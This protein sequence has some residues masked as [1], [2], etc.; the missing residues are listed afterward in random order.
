MRVISGKYRGVTISSPFG[1]RTHPMSERMRSALFTTLG[2]IQGLSVL[3]AYAGSGALGIEA[4]SRGAANVQFIEKDKNAFKIIQKNISK[5]GSNNYKLSR[6]NCFSWS[7]NNEQLKY[8]LI[9]IDPPYN[10]VSTEHI[11]QLTSNLKQTGLLVLS[12][13]RNMSRPPIQNLNIL[14][15][16]SFAD[17]SIVFY[18]Y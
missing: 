11:S 10:E 12:M 18:S 9:F 13:P 17:G 5:I 16:K 3:D 2:D 6:A 1:N 7:L 14:K 15:D 8:D 4:L